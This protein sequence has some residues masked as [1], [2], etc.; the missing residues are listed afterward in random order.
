MGQ[1]DYR[2]AR[3][4]SFDILFHPFELLVTELGETG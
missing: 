1:D 3:R 4:Q 2:R